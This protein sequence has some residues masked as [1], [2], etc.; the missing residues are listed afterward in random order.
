MV[1]TKADKHDD[2]PNHKRGYGHHPL[3]ATCAE[4]DEV[5]AGI[6]RPGNAGSNT[7]I[8]HVT[9]LS[10]ALAQLPTT[11][12]TGHGL[13]DDPGLVERRILVRVD[14]GQRHTGSQKAVSNATWTSLSA[15]TL[16]NESVML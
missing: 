13:G 3:L 4:T 11:W 16:I 6:L 10:D 5:L 2:A 7:A 15:I 8:D 9:L 1:T 12:T 14:A